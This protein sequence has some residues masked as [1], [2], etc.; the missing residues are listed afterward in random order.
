MTARGE[1]DRSVIGLRTRSRIGFS[2]S[3]VR[4][5][6]VRL[7]VSLILSVTLVSLCSPHTIRFAP[8]SEDYDEKLEL[9]AEVR[10]PS[11]FEICVN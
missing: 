10:C 5:L 3:I 4:L 1:N 8:R 11:F 9:R 7:I 2:G 6:R